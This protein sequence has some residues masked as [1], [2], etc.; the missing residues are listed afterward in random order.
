MAMEKIYFTNSHKKKLCGM[1]SDSKTEMKANMAVLM[2]HGLGSHKNDMPYKALQK[3]VGALGIAT[4]SLDLLGHGESDGEYDDLTLTETIDDILCAKHELERRGYKNI[5]FIGSS[6]G[7][8]GG[9]MAAAVEQFKFLVLISP[10]TYYDINEMITSGV[11]ILR[12]L[13]KVNKQTKTT[14]KKKASLNIK[15]FRD[16]G[17]HDSY[18]AGEKIR[19]PV[20]IIQGDKDKIVPIAKSRELRRRIRGAKMK[21]FVGADH[22]YTRVQ[23]QLVEETMKFVEKQ[24]S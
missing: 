5:G 11:Y 12:E 14:E 17:S 18:A 10:P 13:L 3:E 15:F 6:F 23:H 7:G 22:Q 19:A 20:L 16:Y 9:I 21:I 2:C 4:L 1:I 24:K 8:V